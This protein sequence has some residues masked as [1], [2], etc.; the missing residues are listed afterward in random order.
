MIHN[1]TYNLIDVSI[2]IYIFFVCVSLYSPRGPYRAVCALYSAR[3]LYTAQILCLPM[4][5]L[6]RRSSASRTPGPA[7]SRTRRGGASRTR[8]RRMR[9]LKT[10]PKHVQ[11]TSK[12][13]PKSVRK[14]SKTVQK[15]SEKCVEIRLWLEK[16]SH[17]SGFRVVDCGSEIETDVHEEVAID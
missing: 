16:C 11:N 3:G 4:A 10:R 1:R 2:Y 7:S 12:T 8:A 13:R 6:L 14:V 15:V 17:R 5:S 9:R